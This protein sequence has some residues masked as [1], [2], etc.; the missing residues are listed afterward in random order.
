MK[1][2]L[3]FLS[4]FLLQDQVP[5]KPNNQ[6]EI[7]LDF[8][9]KQRPYTTQTPGF[10]SHTTSSTP[11]PYLYLNVKVLKLEAEELRLRIENNKGS[12][13]YSKKAEEGMVAKLDLGFTDDIKD[14]VNSHEYIVYFLSK[15]RKAMSRIVIHFDEDGTYHVNKELRGKL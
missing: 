15:E 6:F 1:L 10:E 11:L 14:R 7:N 8:K 2:L 4:V 9:F 12:S 13:L 3:L 5:F